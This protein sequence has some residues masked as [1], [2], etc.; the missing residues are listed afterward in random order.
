[1]KDINDLSAEISAISLIITGL[2]NSLDEDCTHLAIDKLGTA[3]YGIS[4]H[5]D[6]IAEDMDKL[7][8]NQ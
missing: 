6:R 4:M 7:E 5:L 2:T 8:T 1:M 3:M